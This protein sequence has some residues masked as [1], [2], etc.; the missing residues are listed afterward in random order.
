MGRRDTTDPRATPSTA[1]REEIED[2]LGNAEICYR[3]LVEQVPAITHVDAADEVS[4]TVHISPQAESMLGYAPKE[5]LADPGLWV[6][7]VHPEDRERVPSRERAH[8]SE[9]RAL[10]DGIPAHRSRRP[11]GVGARRGD[12]DKRRGGPPPLPARDHDR[13]H[14]AQGAREQASSSSLS[15][16][17]T[18]S[19]NRPLFREQ[20]ESALQRAERRNQ[21]L[22][23]LYLDLDDF[24]EVNDSLGHEAGDGLLV[25]VAKRLE[26]S[27]RS[28][29]DAVARMGGD[30][31]CVVLED[32][33]GPD[34]AL[35]AASARRRS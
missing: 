28:G 34:A 6:K 16:P 4:S 31:F 15:D 11:D 21:H 20:L 26:A 33:P 25:A 13:C 9:R 32:L 27:S 24:K 29:E 12:N 10:Q 18:G 14:R 7:L 23:V 17:L 22:A 8:Q 2:R 19:S 30:E 3:M 35:R 5:W 1:G